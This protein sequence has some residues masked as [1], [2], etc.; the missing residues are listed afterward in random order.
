MSRDF[1]IAPP[2][3]VDFVF[4]YACTRGPGGHRG[5][6]DMSL[7]QLAF[8]SHGVAH[9]TKQGHEDVM[10]MLLIAQPSLSAT[11]EY[12][13][14]LA[15]NARKVVDAMRESG[16]EAWLH[17]RV[18]CSPLVRPAVLA[19]YFSQVAERDD[20][21]AAQSAMA[22]GAVLGNKPARPTAEA[23]PWAPY[24]SPEWAYGAPRG[25]V[26]TPARAKQSGVFY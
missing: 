4:Q 5:N 19:T 6:K 20:R 3:R 13:G 1:S 21:Q 22:I 15:H 7:E 11:S 23:L 26:P 10:Y 24:E 16:K 2:N 8:A 17:S 12:G 18:P 9:E 14:G 25:W